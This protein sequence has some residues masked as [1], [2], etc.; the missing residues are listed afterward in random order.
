MF[1]IDHDTARRLEMGHTWRSIHHARAYQSIHPGAG[2]EIMSLGSGYAIFEKPGSPVNRCSGLGL[3]GPV[4]RD[5]IQQAEAFFRAHHEPT[6]VILCPLADPSLPKIL[7]GRGYL[8]EQFFSVLA[9][10]LTSEDAA[11]DTPANIVIR[12]MT[13]EFAGE[14]L[15]T[16]ARGFSAPDEPDQELLE[17]LGP[18]FYAANGVTF[19]AYCDGE[20]AGGGGMYL[21]EGVAEFGGASTVP[22]FRR[23]GV[24]TALLKARL[25][26][27]RQEG[28]DLAMVLTEP[29]S[30]S[31]RNL[32]RLGFQVAYTFAIMVSPA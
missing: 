22:E 5:E 25:Q 9:R 6:R 31:Q 12:R 15:D 17:I 16:V 19:L 18:N 29:G 21:H 4:F 14:W 8:L 23:R 28:C 2:V 27:A 26:A 10:P 13:P 20:P 11:A 1:F 32:Q 30:H 3:N 7:Q 24:Q